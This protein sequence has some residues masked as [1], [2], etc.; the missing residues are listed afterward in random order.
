MCVRKWLLANVLLLAIS[1]FAANATI[2]YEFT[3]DSSGRLSGDIEI[4]FAFFA[5][6]TADFVTTD[7]FIEPDDWLSCTVELV[8]GTASCDTHALFPKSTDRHRRRRVQHRAGSPCY[9]GRGLC[10]LL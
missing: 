6:E 4:G 2:L 1:P 7:T 8:I 5:V 10:L 3:A 9:R